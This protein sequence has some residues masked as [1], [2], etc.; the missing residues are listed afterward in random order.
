MGQNHIT[1]VEWEDGRLGTH[2]LLELFDCAALPNHKEDLEHT[3][4]QVAGLAGATV[5][6]SSFHKFSPYGLSGVVVL[7]ESHLA[8]HTWPER[9]TACVDLFSCNPSVSN[10]VVVDFLEETLRAKRVR[11]Q[12][13]SRGIPT[14]I[15]T[16]NLST[17]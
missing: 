14:E 17:S 3:M 5:V 16:N 2:L 4:V 7:A 12:L 11:V 8:I 13:V 6:T 9:K 15:S 1:D 10:Q